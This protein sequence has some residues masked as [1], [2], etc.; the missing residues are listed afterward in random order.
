M[1]KAKKKSFN[2]YGMK[3]HFSI[4]KYHFGAASV[5]LG[6]SL[7]M[8]AGAQTVK[9]E[10]TAAS[11][12]ATTATVASSTDSSAS[13][14]TV[15]A[16]ATVAST[17]ETVA[18]TE[19]TA[20]INYIVQ[21]VLEDGTVVKADVKTT[22]VTTTEAIATSTVEVAT[23][24]PTGYEL[25]TGQSATVSQE[26]TENGE[27]IVTV[28]VVKK[29]EEKATTSET[30]SSATTTA[31]EETTTVTET[32][33]TP[34][35]VEEA[36]VVLEQVTSEAEV[37]ANESER[38]VAA[39]DKENTTLK[40]A[41]TATKLTATEATAVLNDSAATLESVNAQ[42]DAVRTSVEALALEL[43]KYLGTDVIEIALNTSVSNL[44]VT[45]GEG[46]LVGTTS[47]AT[48]T[49]DDP[50]GASVGRHSLPTGVATTE[51]GWFTFAVYDLRS[52]NTNQ[53]GSVVKGTAVPAYIRY[54]LDKDPTT[55]TVLAELVSTEDGRVLEK[56][57][58]EPGAEVALSY[59]T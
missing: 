26:V 35:T 23:E 38:L 14:E 43:R 42:I 13:S 3:Q 1:R 4:R 6:M 15:V 59:P 40:A 44:N 48:P 36:K 34:A 10:E 46:I 19:R 32:V 41:A 50:H 16:E 52:Y 27:N 54:S 28:K 37:L 12:D 29:A 18:S 7:V 33:K 8:G 17:T 51:D 24:L 11:S 58:I 22:S 30:T 56:V 55:A 45:E 21:Y 53:S 2:W 20:T 9:A 57:T 25:V 49:M 47:T 31:I 39:S 5:L